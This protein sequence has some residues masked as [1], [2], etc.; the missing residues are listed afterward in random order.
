MTYYYRRI[1]AVLLG[2]L[3]LDDQTAKGSFAQICATVNEQP[4]ITPQQRSSRLEDVTNSILQGVGLGPHTKLFDK[5]LSRP[6]CMTYVDI[7]WLVGTC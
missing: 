2:A 1:V 6:H 7:L 5:D 3:G 4:G